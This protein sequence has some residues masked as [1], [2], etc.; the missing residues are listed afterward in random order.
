MSTRDRTH[1]IVTTGGLDGACAAAALLLRHPEAEV[2]ITSQHAVHHCLANL[3]EQETAPAEVHVCGVGIQ[4][5]LE[6]A[7]D[8]LGRLRRQGSK[9]TWYCGRGYLDTHEPAFEKVCLPVFEEAGSNTAVVAQR[10]R[11]PRTEVLEQ[12]L[13]LAE[14]FARKR[15][16]TEAQAFWNDL[17]QSASNR[18]FRLGNEAPFL[19]V[20]SLLAGQAQLTQADRDEVTHFRQVDQS[21]PVLLGRSPALKRLRTLIERLGPFDEPV[22]VLG[23]TGAGKELVARALHAASPRRHHIFLPVNCA[24]LGGHTDLAHDRLFGHARGAYTGADRPARGAF[25]E[26]T[27]GTLFLD[28]VA[29]LPLSTQTQLLRVLEEGTVTPLGTMTPRKVDVRIVAATNQDLLALVAQ[30]RFRED[31]YHRLCVLQLEVPPLREHLEDARALVDTLLSNLVSKDVRLKLGPRDWEAIQGYPWPGNVRELASML[32][33]AAYTGDTLAEVIAQEA[34]H[35]ER[36]EQSA[37]DGPPGQS[38]QARMR[39]GLA[40]LFHPTSPEEVRPFDEVQRAFMTHVLGLFGG[41]YTQARKA[42]GVSDNTLRRWTRPGQIN[43][44][45]W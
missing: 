14:A 23:P 13:S 15:K 20:L 40:T 19:R 44:P 31:L 7:L 16:L 43:L 9:V 11:L 35:R 30:G 39:S 32:K 10:L 42:M 5:N 21:K 17:L 34:A 18:F 1:V 4:D 38:R 22:L 29:E 24:I 2:R 45:G 26:A 27:G 12:L 28:E 25:E 41:N 33:R 36:S 8:A 6:A 3:L 37:V